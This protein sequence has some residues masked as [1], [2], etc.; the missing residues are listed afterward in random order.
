MSR[1][2]AF[3]GGRKL[4]GRADVFAYER[5]EI[6]QNIVLCHTASEVLQDVVNRDTGSLYA[7]LA[8]ADGRIDN[9]AVS[10][11]HAAILL[12]AGGKLKGES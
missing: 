1:K 10:V 7:G 6:P 9:D 11:I 8:A 5:W 2:L 3:T 12:A 4:E